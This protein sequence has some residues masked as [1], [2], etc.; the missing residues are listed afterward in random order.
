MLDVAETILIDQATQADSMELMAQR[1]PHFLN[2]LREQLDEEPEVEV[3]EADSDEAQII[4]LA[5]WVAAANQG[6]G[7]SDA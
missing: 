6:F 4:D 3:L 1:Q 7:S 5:G 2:D